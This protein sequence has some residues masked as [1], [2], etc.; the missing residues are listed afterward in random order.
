MCRRKVEI[1]I[2]GNCLWNITTLSWRE[3]WAQAVR[4]CWLQ[5]NLIRYSESFE[6]TGFCRNCFL[7]QSSRP[8]AISRR[9]DSGCI[10]TTLAIE[11]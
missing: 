8:Q 4:I 7:S 5:R 2:S 1:L 9:H 11:A 10:L 3:K 6:R